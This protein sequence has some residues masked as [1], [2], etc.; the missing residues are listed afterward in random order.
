MMMTYSDVITIFDLETIPRKDA[1]LDD[2]EVKAGNIKDPDKIKAKQV[3]K[4]S[5]DGGLCQ[6]LSIAALKVDANTGDIIDEFLMLNDKHDVDMIHQFIAFSKDTALCGWNIKGFDIP[7][8]WKRGMIQ[9]LG[10]MS[11]QRYLNLTKK[12]GDGCLDLMQVWGNYG[13]VSQDSCA[14]ALDIETMTEMDGSKVYD[15]FLAGEYDKIKAYNM[16]DVT[17]CYEIYKRLFL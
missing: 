13:L 9:G 11:T 1:S 7:V 8:L 15:A 5:L 3:K 6:V 17:I 16:Q 12:Y 10:A 4:A 2:V 14:K